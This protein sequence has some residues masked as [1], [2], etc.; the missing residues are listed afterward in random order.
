MIKSTTGQM[1]NNIKNPLE[2]FDHWEDDLVKRY[3]EENTKAKE[4][5]RDYSTSDRAESVQAFYKLN[6]EF[7]TYDFI[8]QKEK[9]FL[10]FNK[11]EMSLCD[12]VDFLN[13][14]VD[15]SNSDID[16][17]Q[18]QHLLQTSESIRAD[19]HELFE[20]VKKF[21]PYGLYSIAPTPPNSKALRPYYEELVAKY[22]PK[23]LQF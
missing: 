19:G 23:T 14:L 17:D 3:P 1:K 4:E 20:W 21:N 5:Y 22:L 2:S 9:E 13:T 18:F 7:Q 12:A 16:L 11:R 8:C 6:H 15:D 10:S